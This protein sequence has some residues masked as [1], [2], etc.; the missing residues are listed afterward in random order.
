[1]ERCNL[2][3]RVQNT[4]NA[5][6]KLNGEVKSSISVPKGSAVSIEITADG[7]ETYKGVAKVAEN[8]TLDIRLIKVCDCGEDLGNKVEKLV[9]E[10]VAVATDGLEEKIQGNVEDQLEGLISVKVEPINSA[11][12][13]LQQMD[14]DLNKRIDDTNS[15]L[16]NLSNQVS[17]IP[18]TYLTISNFN[19][20]SEE[21]KS[22]LNNRIDDTNSNLSD[23]SNQVS[24][25][26]NT[27]L[28]IANFNSSS[29]E[30]KSDLNRRIDEKADIADLTRVESQSA[31]MSGDIVT[32][33]ST[34]EIMQKQIQALKTPETEA[35]DPNTANVSQP[36]KNIVI[37][38]GSVTTT[39]DEKFTRQ[40]TAKSIQVEDIAVESS[41][42]VFDANDDVV[43]SGFESSGDLKK[44]TANAAVSIYSNADVKITNSTVNQTG[45]NAIEIGLSDDKAPKNVLID[46]ITF[47]SKM[48][49]NAILIFAH[50]KDALITISNCY[51]K[52][53]SNCVRLSNRL[54]VPAKVRFVNCTCD[55]WDTNPQWNGFLI[56][57]DYT[58]KTKEEYLEQKR[59]HNLDIQ[60]VNC[61]GPFGKIEGTAEELF[62]NNENQVA[63]IYVD[64]D[65]SFP[66]YNEAE[67]PKCSAI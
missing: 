57:E 16:S 15:N 56:L 24:D 26:P 12:T 32:I 13:E 47:D 37:S 51:F 61:Y 65:L 7:L 66:V 42:V 14:L 44:S 34:L 23:L 22:N 40:I 5:T 31:A 48:S 19:S 20:S 52:D 60:F 11:I 50:Q 33:N 39:A 25:I 4:N 62:S 27:Y 38:N 30:M 17:D 45:Y 18:N 8:S 58:S 64:A 2:S 6:I 49:N 53:V 36:D 35:A 9:D 54:N 41:R 29:E 67:F 46:G 21:M 55:K 3:V 59:F 43:I 28:T 63:Y 1:M 10:A